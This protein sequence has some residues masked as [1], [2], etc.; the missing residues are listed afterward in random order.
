MNSNR[1]TVVVP[2]TAEHASEV[3]AIYQAGI[4]EGDATFETRAPAWEEFDRARLG[5]HRFVV[6]D[7][8][9]RVLGWVAVSRVS[10]RR[11]YAGVVEHSV[12]VRPDARG[13]GVARAL[14]E[15]LIASTEAAGIWTVQ[16]GIFPENAA[17]LA[18]HERAGF[19]V[20]GTRERVGRQHGVWRDVVLV[21]RRSPVVD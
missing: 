6:V 11:A 2:M 14:L 16:S 13:R 7:G 4:D 18:L 12:Y 10:D 9:G 1:D 19:R 8:G 17:S 21:E 3:L 20:I 15:A 5:G